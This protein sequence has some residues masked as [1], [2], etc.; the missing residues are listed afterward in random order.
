MVVEENSYNP[1]GTSETN[2]IFMKFELYNGTNNEVEASDFISMYDVYKSTGNRATILETATMGGSRTGHYGIYNVAVQPEETGEFYFAALM[3]KAQ[4]MPYIKV[5]DVYLNTNPSAKI[6]EKHYTERTV[7]K[8]T[9]SENGKITYKCSVCG[10][11]VKTETIYR[12][13]TVTLSYTKKTYSG[14]EIQPKVTVKDSKGN[15]ISSKNYTVS[16]KNNKNVGKATVTIK[17]KG[18]Y[19]GTLTKTFTI[20]PKGTSVSKVTAKSKGFDV[21]WKKQSTQTT[22]YQIQYSTSSKF[23][24]K[25]TK[26]IRVTSASTVTKTV[27]K[28]KTATKYYVR[29]RTYKTVSGTNYYSDWSKIVSVKTKK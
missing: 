29:V 13:K 6:G 15:I 27:S 8:A 3:P 19:K 14:K 21:T 22:G 24:E 7:A 26:T 16:Y 28:L 5:G 9:T 1:R 10:N 17:F 20:N 18:N 11:N 2:W 25:T 12:P 4:G 23:T